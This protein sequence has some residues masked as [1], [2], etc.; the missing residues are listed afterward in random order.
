MSTDAPTATHWQW[1]TD[2]AQSVR[3][4][5]GDRTSST[6]GG[7][8]ARGRQGGAARGGHPPPEKQTR[9]R[10]T[11]VAA[12]RH[13]REGRCVGRRVGAPA[14]QRGAAPTPPSEVG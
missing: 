3:G 14:L 11:G 6:G 10:R 1:W 12:D 9:V 8:G 4:N 13:T 7:G 5:A 2:G